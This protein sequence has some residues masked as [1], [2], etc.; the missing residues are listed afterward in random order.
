MADNNQN[1]AEQY[2]KERKERLA[3]AAKKNA[4]NIEKKTKYTPSQEAVITGEVNNIL[5]SAA[6]GSGKTTVLVERIIRKLINDRAEIDSFL[7]AT[8]TNAAANNMK[9]K[10]AKEI[11]KALKNSDD[12]VIKNHLKRQLIKIWFLCAPEQWLIHFK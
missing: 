4:K 9:L 2:R 1:K 8:F 3:K 6:A 12:T 7:I 11:R 10:I 5:V